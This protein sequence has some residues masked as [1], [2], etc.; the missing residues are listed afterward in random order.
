MHVNICQSKF[1]FQSLF[2]FFIYFFSFN[3]RAVDRGDWTGVGP[4][5]TKKGAHESAF[6]VEP[7]KNEGFFCC[8]FSRCYCS[9]SVQFVVFNVLS[10]LLFIPFG[11]F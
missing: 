7:I 9:F 6:F 11:T 2:V 8:S 4:N 1:I 3:T 10:I 5:R